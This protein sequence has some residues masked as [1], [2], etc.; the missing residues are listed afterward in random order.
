MYCTSLSSDK[1][2]AVLL[3]M[4]IFSYR[5]SKIVYACSFSTN[6][7]A[8]FKSSSIPNQVDPKSDIF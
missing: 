8:Q 7:I 6:F 2:Q 4:I 5:E 1:Y 3:E